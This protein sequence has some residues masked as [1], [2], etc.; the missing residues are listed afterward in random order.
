ML[1]LLEFVAAILFVLMPEGEAE[2]VL[3]VELDCGSTTELKY[4]CCKA[5]AADIRCEGSNW[6]IFES[7][8]YPS[9]SSPET[10]EVIFWD[11]Y[12]GKSGL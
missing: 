7:K 4:G 10:I 1:V 3:A 6:S 11:G 8:S 2:V 9:S 5:L 12:T